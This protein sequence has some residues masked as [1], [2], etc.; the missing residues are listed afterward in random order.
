MMWTLFST[1]ACTSSLFI[2]LILDAMHWEGSWMIY[3]VGIILGGLEITIEGLQELMKEKQ[4]NVDLLMIIAAVSAGIIGDWREGALLI[5]I[6][7]LSHLMEEY[8][9]EKS[10]RA[11]NHLVNR[12]PKV[13]RMI[14]ANGDYQLVDVNQVTIGDRLAVFKG[15]HIPTDAIILQGA[16]ELDESIVN[17]ESIPQLKQQGAEVFGGTINL[18]NE[19]IIEV[20]KEQSE[21]VFSKIIQLVEEAQNSQT[22]TET[23]IQKIENRYVLVILVGVPL[24]ILFFHFGWHWAWNE[25]VYRGVNLLVVA[26]PCALVASSTPALLSAISNGA[27][28]G[29]LFKGGTYLE[30]LAEIKSIAFDKTGTLTTGK[31]NVTDT[32]W[33]IPEEEIIPFVIG[34]EEKSTHP[35][36]QAIV[37]HWPDSPKEPLLVEELTAKGIQSL[38]N[39]IHYYIGK[40]LGSYTE[41]SMIQEWKKQGKTVVYVE[42]NRQFVGAIALRDTLNPHAKEVIHYFNEAHV[43]TMMLTGDNPHT[44]ETIAREI[45]IHD[46]Q[47]NLLP[48]DKVRF[49]NEQKQKFG[50][51]AM[52]GDGVNDA[53]AL[54]SATI[55]IAMG[56][57]TDVA[58]DIADV[59][60]LE[61][62][63]SKLIYTHQLSQKMKHVIIQ[64]IC[65]SIAVILLLI[66]INLLQILT[67]PLAVIGHEGSTILVILNGLRLLKNIA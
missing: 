32:F 38:H 46:Y 45:G 29:V 49:L 64:N 7:S 57:G 17:G 5:F 25:S 15:E 23:F 9:T 47:A 27:R 13:A 62:N 6:F 39:G 51:T 37:R 3:L 55:G 41:P 58:M 53:P 10:A 22:K 35:L 2:G 26:S 4:F 34:L 1:L 30:A 16:S 60:I 18:G 61:N 20:N 52:L 43:H 14:L 33:T 19:L 65:F 24:A 36:A 31:P 21:T 63:L 8:A 59:V 44:A 56:E 54:A 66:A 48:A 42:R 28:H 50:K 67:I 11:I 40:K 12:Q